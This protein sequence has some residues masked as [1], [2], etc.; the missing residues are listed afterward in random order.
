ML[1]LDFVIEFVASLTTAKFP[2]PIFSDDFF[3]LSTNDVAFVF[4]SLIKKLGIFCSNVEL[5]R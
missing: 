5:I 3:F 2:F 4:V 1:T